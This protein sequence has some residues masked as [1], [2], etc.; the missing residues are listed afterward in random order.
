MHL[1]SACAAWACA[2]R[3]YSKQVLDDCLTHVM[4]SHVQ[5]TGTYGRLS[6]EDLLL[7]YGFI[8][9][10][11]I[12]GDNR[13]GLALPSEVSTTTPLWPAQARHAHVVK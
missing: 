4:Y 2:R 1:S 9:W 5:V 10:P 6:N 8:P 3:R 11:Y 7:I 12:H 13:F